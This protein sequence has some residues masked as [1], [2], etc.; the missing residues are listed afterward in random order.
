MFP[1]S[2]TETR[3][4]CK[5]LASLPAES[6]L[7]LDLTRDQFRYWCGNKSIMLEVAE[8]WRALHTGDTEPL[9]SASSNDYRTQKIWLVTVM[10]QRLWEM[11]IACFPGCECI[12]ELL[13]ISFLF[14]TP[15]ELFAHILVESANGEFEICLQPYVEISSPKA[16]KDLKWLAKNPSFEELK[17]QWDTKPGKKK[18]ERMQKETEAFL[19]QSGGANFWLNF[20]LLTGLVLSQ[21]KQSNAFVKSSVEAYNQSIANLAKLDAKRYHTAPSPCWHNGVKKRGNK[22]G[23]YS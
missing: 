1:Y 15:L 2:P 20:V 21:Y 6:Y 4:I 9:S 17:Q 8:H 18:L 13:N 19:R 10:W 16:E 11:T 3:V 7:E 23:T 22:D 5:I 14:R 12:A